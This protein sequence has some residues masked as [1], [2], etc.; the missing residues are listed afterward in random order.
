MGSIRCIFPNFY[1]FY[2]FNPNVF[3]KFKQRRILMGSNLFFGKPIDAF[4]RNDNTLSLFTN[5]L[6]ARFGECFTQSSLCH[7]ILVLTRINMPAQSWCS[8]FRSQKGFSCLPAGKSDKTWRYFRTLTTYVHST[9]S[10]GN[11]EV[12]NSE[13]KRQRFQFFLLL[14]RWFYP[15]RVENRSRFS[16]WTLCQ[17][18]VDV[19]IKQRRSLWSTN[20]TSCQHVQISPKPVTRERCKS[21]STSK[22][23]KSDPHLIIQLLSF[24]VYKMVGCVIIR[25][26]II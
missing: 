12:S 4:H 9:I 16:S 6:L 1:L 11:C 2:R 8:P 25:R 24:W 19:N 3:E 13:V 21:P 15:L 22:Y 26:I 23:G 14:R 5:S 20:E 7:R 10:S 18:N 17:R